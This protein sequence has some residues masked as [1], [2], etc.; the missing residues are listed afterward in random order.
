MIPTEMYF[1]K[2]GSWVG[3]DLEEQ[4][5]HRHAKPANKALAGEEEEKLTVSSEK[6][7]D[8]QYCK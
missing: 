5:L 7:W 8:S 6:G 1:E 2:Q 3:E 4:E